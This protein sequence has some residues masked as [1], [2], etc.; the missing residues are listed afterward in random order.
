MSIN[1]IICEMNDKKK[2]MLGFQKRKS[3]LMVTMVKRTDKGRN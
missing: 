2:I 3:S 1:M